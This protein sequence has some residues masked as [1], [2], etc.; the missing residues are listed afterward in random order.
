FIDAC[1]TY[2]RSVGERFGS[3][4]AA[5]LD[6]GGSSENLNSG[7][8]LIEAAADGESA[9]GDSNGVSRFTQALLQAL[10]GYCGAPQPGSQNWLV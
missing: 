9:Y 2:V 10:G 3:G 1:R 6:D 7:T 4:P 8:T 5:L